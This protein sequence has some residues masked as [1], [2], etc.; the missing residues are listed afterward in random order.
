MYLSI[1]MCVGTVTPSPSFAINYHIE[2]F[3]EFWS[4]CQVSWCMC[5]VVGAFSVAKSDNSSN[6][7]LSTPLLKSVNIPDSTDIIHITP[8]MKHYY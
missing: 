5:V 3:V 8:P 6:L 2:F 1:Y 7:S 4:L